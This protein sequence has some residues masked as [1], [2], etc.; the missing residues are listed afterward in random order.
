MD[1]RPFKLVICSVL[2]LFISFSHFPEIAAE[3][4]D[5]NGFYGILWGS[6]LADVSNLVLV[7]S[8]PQIQTYELKGGPVKLGEAEVHMQLVAID[9]Q[10]ARASIRYLGEANHARMLAYL[11]SRFGP[12]EGSPGSMIRGLNQQY[13]W[14]NDETEVNLTY[15]S[16]PERGS[17]FIESRTLAPR[18]TDLLPDD[19]L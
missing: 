13:T 17:V 4:M 12:I 9:G 7:Q 1:Q 5:I 19:A 8:T 16:S 10:F 6:N 11:Q 3:E 14:R 15:Q 2:L 18:F